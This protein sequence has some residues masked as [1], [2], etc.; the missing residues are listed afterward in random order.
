MSTHY[1]I[2]PFSAPRQLAYLAPRR[3][4]DC[5]ESPRVAAWRPPKLVQLNRSRRGRADFGRP[6]RAR[7]IILLANEL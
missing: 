6:A 4:R 3:D 5:R 1:V 7:R 2:R